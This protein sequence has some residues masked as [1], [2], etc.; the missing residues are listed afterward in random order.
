MDF[1]ELFDKIRKGEISREDAHEK[2]SYGFVET[3]RQSILDINRD[4]RTGIPEIVYGEYKSLE[5]VIDISENILTREPLVIVSRFP[6][7]DKL[8]EVLIKKHPVISG[9]NIF[10]A[11]NI[12]E[13]VAPVLVISAGAADRPV[14]E[15]IEITLKAI[16]IEPLL[17][18]D[19]G[20]A[21]PTRVL[22]AI[23]EGIKRKV[24]AIIVIAGMEGAL[25]T[26]VSSL[27][28]LPV[29][30]VPTSVGYGYHAKDS[31]LISMLAS[32]TPNLAVVNIDGGVRAA[33]IAS[34]IAKN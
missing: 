15:E 6:E 26:F 28:P 7:N 8:K 9:K 32:C 33:V 23:K 16:A 17:F 1:N 31:A 5:Q 18:E 4:L 14:T 19:R 30:G 3:A 24:K 20:I 10:V 34:L 12:P 21:H 13:P 22:E 11:G 2:V 29:I 25:A 27:I